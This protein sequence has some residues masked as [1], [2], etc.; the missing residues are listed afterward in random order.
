MLQ[1]ERE[2]DM[3]PAMVVPEVSYHWDSLSQTIYDKIME[4]SGG[5]QGKRILEA[6]SGTGKISLRLAAEH[7]EVTLVDYSENALFNSRSAFYKAKVPHLC[8]LR[9]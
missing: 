5:I 7:A 6:G 4:V 8:S 1:N 9:H 3:G 2:V